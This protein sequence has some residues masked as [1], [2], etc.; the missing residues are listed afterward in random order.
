MIF[1]I[2]NQ[3]IEGEPVDQNLASE[4]VQQF[5]INREIKTFKDLERIFNDDISLH[6]KENE[7]EHV[8][9]HTIEAIQKKIH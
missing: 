7:I 5:Q 8:S 9:S 1:E 3:M 2:E 6:P 4:I